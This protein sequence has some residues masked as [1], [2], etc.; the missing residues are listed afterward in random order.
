MMS[1]KSASFRGGYLLVKGDLHKI[2]LV[3]Y[4]SS[5]ISK[6]H[7]VAPYIAAAN[8]LRGQS[9]VRGWN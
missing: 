9:D 4:M 7:I 3:D 6:Q 2:I 8:G 5:K 1:D